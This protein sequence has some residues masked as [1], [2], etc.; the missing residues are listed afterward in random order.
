MINGT[1]V[2]V[3]QAVLHVSDLSILRGYGIFDFFLARQGH[4]L[5]W[6]D[7]AHRFY[8]SAT[9]AG[10]QVPV[11]EPVLREQVY[12]LLRLNE[13]TDAGVRFVLTGGYSPDGYT[14]AETA[15][16][17]MMLHELPVNVWETAGAG[18]K[19]ITHDYQRE[20]PEVKTINYATGI[21]MLPKI[22]EAGAQDLVYHSGGWI[23][24]SARS[25][26]YIID[27]KGTI[28]TPRE[29][30][31]W[32]VTRK[33]VLESARANNI[34]VEERDVH[35]DEIFAASEAFFTSSTKGVMPITHIDGQLIGQGTGPL[36][37]RLQT[38]FLEKVRVYLSERA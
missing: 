36:A 12:T 23:R 20:L 4:P 22:K 11:P 9:R 2:P 6:E 32:G 24:E 15:N 7:Y 8:T 29:Q 31:L 1:P 17:V 34:P 18:M 19:I 33:K 26:F 28:V 10:L 14:P 35:M 30:I 37:Q 3:E 5:F 25:N 16:L 27:A 13:R 38:L 21:R